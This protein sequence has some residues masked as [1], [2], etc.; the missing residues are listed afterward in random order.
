MFSLEMLSISPS[1]LSDQDEQRYYQLCTSVL[2]RECTYLDLLLTLSDS[3]DVYPLNM[4]IDVDA[5][6]FSTKFLVSSDL[7]RAACIPLLSDH[8]TFA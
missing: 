5:S 8:R 3:D 6:S 4:I 2:R 1:L 7:V